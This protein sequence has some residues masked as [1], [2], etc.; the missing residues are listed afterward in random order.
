MDSVTTKGKPK[1]IMSVLREYGKTL[2][3]ENTIPEVTEL[4]D[5]GGVV[6]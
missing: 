4:E 1:E 2:R 5:H 3:P 6:E